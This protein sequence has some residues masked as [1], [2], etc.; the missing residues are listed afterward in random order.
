MRFAKINKLV[1]AIG[2]TF[3]GQYGV[4]HCIVIIRQ[5]IKKDYS[6]YYEPEKSN[7]VIPEHMLRI[8]RYCYCT[9]ESLPLAFRAVVFPV[10][11]NLNE[12][13]V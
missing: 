6:E 13:L 7:N 4:S 5:V 9:P 8:I 10:S 3:P 11:E 1:I 2:V 12:L